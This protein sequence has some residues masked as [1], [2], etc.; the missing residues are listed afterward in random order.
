MV[1][2]LERVVQEKLHDLFTEIGIIKTCQDLMNRILLVLYMRGVESDR[3]KISNPRN[4]FEQV[5]HR[6]GFFIKK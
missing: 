6:K 3:P 2:F 4:E 5:V 1:K